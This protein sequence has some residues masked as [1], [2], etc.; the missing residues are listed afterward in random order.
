MGL[1]VCQ[2]PEKQRLKLLVEGLRAFDPAHLGLALGCRSYGEAVVLEQRGTST[3]LRK[4]E[5][6]ENNE[7]LSLLGSAQSLQNDIL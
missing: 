6:C 3:G 4:P 1:Q 7:P 5:V 2:E